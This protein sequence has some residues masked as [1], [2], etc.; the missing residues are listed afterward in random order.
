MDKAPLHERPAWPGVRMTFA[1]G[2]TVS[3]LSA[4]AIALEGRCTARWADLSILQPDSRDAL[5][6]ALGR[7]QSFALDLRLGHNAASA[8]I[9]MR[10]VGHWDAQ[11]QAHVC[12]LADATDLHTAWQ[13]TA[14]RLALL[15]EMVD[16]LPLLIIQLNARPGWPCV[17]AGGGLLELVTAHSRHPVGRD[18]LGLFGPALHAQLQT[19][20]TDNDGQPSRT[21]LWRVVDA[22]GEERVL[23]GN[24]CTLTD[25]TG[26][27]I[28]HLLDALETTAYHATMAELQST[29][30]RVRRFVTASSDGVVICA[31]QRIIDANP[32]A[33]QLLSLPVDAL[34]LRR[35]SDLVAPQDLASYEAHIQRSSEEALDCH[36]ID[37][38]GAHQAVELLV[39][40]EERQGRPVRMMIIRDV[41]DRRETQ[42]RIQAL[43]AD[44]RAQKDKAEAADRAKSLF[45]S[46]ASHDLRQPIHA[47]SLLLTSLDALLQ[48]PAPQ[49]PLLDD[50]SRRMGHSLDALSRLLNSLLDVSRLDANAVPV[51][52]R[53]VPL[54]SVFEELEDNLI[55][56]A[57]LKG[58]RLDVV[59]SDAWVNSDPVVL[60]RV[61][62]NLVANA[63]RYTHKGRVLVVARQ[64]GADIE[65]QV[66]DTG[67]GIDRNHL[68][69]IFGE[70][71]RIKP[72]APS[73]AEQPGLGL[74]LSIVQRSAKLL[75]AT[76]RVRSTPGRG[77][78]F[79]VRV[80]GADSQVASCAAAATPDPADDEVSN[81]HGTQQKRCV[82]V[83]DDDAMVVVAMQQLLQA[84]GHEVWCASDPDQAIV[85]AVTHADEID[86]VLTDYH[87]S[88]HIDATHFIDAL[89]TCIANP[90]P[91]YVFTAD[92][93]ARVA[94]EVHSRGLHLMHKP[95]REDALQQLLRQPLPWK[96]RDLDRR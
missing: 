2:G 33:C 27:P 86:L 7:R 88:E 72:A 42:A 67:I 24:L 53:A 48:A 15:Q 12:Q 41:R 79:S 64:R 87:L 61:L 68:D 13:G 84:W 26:R 10:C 40:H 22:Q 5:S 46:A 44:L 55:E 11:Q 6:A 23:E 83:I 63:I 16:S 29:Q 93:S 89:R 50:V 49:V 31:D 56:S 54:A 43:I 71:Y 75:G 36:L 58:L 96:D 18:A 90:V 92:T 77:S 70:F 45:L 85:L 57:R 81:T 94:R 51:H 66:W 69:D 76:L 20:L 9:A 38:A 28:S 52:L 78:V 3:D 17:F 65:I 82:L 47:F 25:A 1:A 59:T 95:V 21:F 39:R 19:M 73:G 60:G 4:E 74:G 91:V 37:R 32:A 30:E 14:N 34:R 8:P 80:P 35:F 62:E